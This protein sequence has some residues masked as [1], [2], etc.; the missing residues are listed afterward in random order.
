L[1]RYNVFV[2][3]GSGVVLPFIGIKMIDLLLHHV[4][5]I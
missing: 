4:G 2:Y 1:L 5:G 3:G